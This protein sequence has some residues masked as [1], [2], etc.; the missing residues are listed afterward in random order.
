MPT[1]PINDLATDP[2]NKRAPQ[3][4][5]VAGHHRRAAERRARTGVVEQ[6]LADVP[7]QAII[8][9]LLVE[10]VLEGSDAAEGQAALPAIPVGILTATQRSP[11]LPRSVRGGKRRLKKKGR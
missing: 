5:L 8:D 3:E 10:A 6:V 11:R 1:I 9:G 7:M 4:T 2:Q